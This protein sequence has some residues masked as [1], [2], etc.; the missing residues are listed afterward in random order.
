[1][2]VVCILKNIY[3][4]SIGAKVL[5]DE[6]KVVNMRT[7]DLA[8]L[9][10]IG[11]KLENAVITRDGFVRARSGSLHVEIV[12]QPSPLQQRDLR[13]SNMFI[14]TK[15]L[16]LYHGTKEPSLVPRY[17]K[18]KALNDYG[19]GFYMTN[20]KELA[21]EW[22]CAMYT[23]GANS[24]IYE[25]SM[26]IEGLSILNLSKYNAL[27]WV[28]VLC[29]YR[30]IDDYDRFVERTPK[31][32]A[33]FLVKNYCLDID[34]YD[35]IVG[36]RADDSFFNYVNDFLYDLISLE[37]LENVLRYGDLGLQFVCKSKESFNRLKFTGKE[38]VATKY[39][40]KYKKRVLNANNRYHSLD[41]KRVEGQTYISD[42]IKGE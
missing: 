40:D 26:S 27:Y 24:Y 12:G 3:N 5:N 39:S 8:G 30:V 14:E 35:M 31:D 20:D 16:V 15:P 17:G 19:V 13:N 10:R 28:A 33:E 38:V 36:Y 11:V 29:K 21:R 34:N 2:K 41:R 6:N 37:S 4:K 42:L 32:R 25:Y 1:M 23:R 22:S 18:G 7:S 9:A